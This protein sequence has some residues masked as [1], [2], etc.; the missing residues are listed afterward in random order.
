[1]L[2]RISA[3][4]SR[5][6][7][8]IDE[9]FFVTRQIQ[10]SQLQTGN[11]ALLRLDTHSRILADIVK[12]H[13]QLQKMLQNRVLVENQQTRLSTTTGAITFNS[14]NACSIVGI[15]AHLPS[16]QQ[17]YCN[18][19]CG[20]NCHESHY[21]RSYPLFDKIIGSL[22]VGYSGFPGGFYQKCSSTLCTA[23][24]H[25]QTRICYFFP[26]WLAENMLDL[27][28]M[29]SSAQGPCISLTVRGV[30]KTGSEIYRCIVHDDVDGLRSLFDNGH[31]CPNDIEQ[32]LGRSV[33]MVSP[34][35]M[36][37]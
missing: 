20:C 26:T 4:Q 36:F 25:F 12:D 17:H 18:S 14:P 33:L 37:I 2:I 1:M 29:N 32:V 22:F 8:I 7:L 5:I 16:L 23:Q 24:Q 13:A 9:V 30:H 10:S 21:F 3:Q 6:R 11:D 28:Y 27:M 15:R 31:A 34:M 35:S 19:S